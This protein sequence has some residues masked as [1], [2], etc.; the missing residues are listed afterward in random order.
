MKTI[1]GLDLGTT[2][3]GWA[4]VK[5]AETSEE[6]SS[7]VKLGV[8]VNPLTVDEQTNFSKGRPITTNADRTLKRSA[9]RNLQRYKLRRD[10]LIEVLKE[11]GLIMDDVV[12]A[13]HGAGSTF[14]TLGLRAKAAGEKVSLEELA[15]IL[16]MLNKKRG[17]KSS[18][19]A[20]NDDEGQIIDGMS[21]AKELYEKGLTPGQYVY[22]SLLNGKKYIPDFYRSDLQAEFDKVWNCQK[23][24]YNDLLTDELKS[25]LEGKNEKQTWV[26]CEK[27]FGIAGISRTTKGDELKKENYLWRAKAV[28]EQMDLESLAVVFQ[29]INS[30]INGSSGYLGAISDRS[31]ELYFNNLTVGQYLAQKVSEDS[32]FSLKNIV[33]YRQDY[34]DEF[35]RI[36][37]VQAKYHPELTDDLKKQIRDIVIFYQRPL[38]S[39]KGLVSICELEG[40]EIEV[41][42]EGKTKKKLVGP[43]VCPKSSPLFQEFKIWQV[44]NNLTA[45]KRYLSQDEKERLY[46]RLCTCD[47]LSK[48][49]IIKCLNPEK[50]ARER[51]QD[52]LFAPE[53]MYEAEVLVRLENKKKEIVLNYKEID[54]NRTMAALFKACSKIIVL[55]G[56]DEYDFSKMPFSKAAGIISDIFSALGYRTDF[57]YFDSSL[58]GKAFEE[59][60]SYRLWHLLYSYEGDKSVS[61]NEKLISK[62]TEI[63]GLEPE[64]AKVLANVTFAPDYGSLSTK[65]MK[66]ILTFMKEGNEYSLACMYAGY[67]HSKNSLTKEQIDA[68]ILKEHLEILPKNSLRNPVVEKILNQMANVVNAVIDEYGRP[69]E[70]RIEL[71]RELKKSAAERDELSKAVASA[72][73]Q[74]T[75]IRETLQKEFGI[76][77]PSRNDVIRY[78]LYEELKNNGYKTLYSGTY[79]SPEKIF[80]KD[81][82]IEHI[83]PQSRLFDDSFS[84]KTLEAR[85]VNL[86]K[87]NATAYDYVKDKY[88]EAEVEKYVARVEQLYKAGGISKAKR[89]KLLMQM[90]DIPS[91]FIAR[92]LRDSQYIARKAKSMLEEIVRH[93]VSTTGSVTDRLR[94]DW[95]LVDVM[96]ELNWDKYDRLGL[97]EIVQDHDGRRIK[98]IRDWTKRNDHRHHAMDALTIAFTKL[99]YI[100]YLNNLNA[101]VRK[102]AGKE[103]MADLAQYSVLDIPKSERADVVMAIER[104]QLYRD[105]VGGRL[106]FMP[107]M[108]LDEFRREARRHLEN[109]LVSIK[110]KNKVVT[111]N[112]NSTKCKGGTNKK[113][114]LTPRGQL[115][116]ETV[117]G[118]IR[119]YAVKSEKVGVTFTFEKIAKVASPVYRTALMERLKQFGG[120]PKKAFSGKNSIDKSPVYVD[121]MH[122]RTVPEKVALLSMEEMFTV[123][124]PVTPDLKVDKVVDEGIRRILQAR[125]DEYGG[126]PKK[127]FSDLDGNPVWLNKD[128]GIQVKSVK[129]KGIN[130]AVALHDKCDHYGRPVMNADGVRIPTDYVSPGNNHHVAIFRDAEG[131]LQEQVV[132]FYDA[133][134]RV[135]LG[136]PVIDRE[137]KKDEGWEFLFTMKQNEYFVFPNPETGFDPNEYDL[138]NPDN[139]A[140]IS[141]NLFRV[142]KLATK[143]YVFRHH[144]ETNVEEKNELRHI[145][146]ERIQNT[147]ALKGI[148]K[149][150]I[151]HIGQIVQV[152]E[153]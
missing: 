73:K 88:G 107:P 81:F 119:R 106:R 133:V 69:D 30:Q 93:V 112:V 68:K 22:K 148:V 140:V 34:M 132:S 42:C 80:S 39:Q 45:N 15:R 23:A 136:I 33:F 102:E 122:T 89:N 71:A 32:H 125:L 19:K 35:E 87:G 37:S 110:A 142:Q 21:I 36:W 4:L 60:A 9:R 150:R 28:E 40:R 90:A 114:Q 14:E 13:E 64:Y 116:N 105:K 135:T 50:S 27:H 10:N 75:K 25:E 143:N 91:D 145:A 85:Q 57:L 99:S 146:W 95:Q 153:Y 38:K 139:Y 101:R 108:P 104:T 24:F 141:P 94:E 18:R 1:L 82:D 56:H 55:T 2:S 53:E 117:Y 120:D 41:T 115:H 126:D 78:R 31:K 98:K 138:L 70:I 66:R 137:Y 11:A 65:A 12:L 92:D 76:A 109:T 144:L 74:H 44:L 97:T 8:R 20:K 59:Q 118:K 43:R 7:I 129:I 103:Y 128:K 63:T 96:K 49:E 62:I 17:Y 123:R 152:G 47:K 151:N 72:D 48:S 130:N 124:K 67:N 127:A 6:K 5:E 26:I 79:I 149:V 111:R 100:Q 86:D 51:R 134:A 131:N 52:S 58:E 54:G 147:N 3:I 16:L 113:V 29:K 83:I 46:D 121:A 77:N 61:G 84:N